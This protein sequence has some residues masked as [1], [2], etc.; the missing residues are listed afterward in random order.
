MDNHAYRLE[1]DIK[2]ARAYVNF[3]DEKTATA[4][5]TIFDRL[6]YPNGT[7]LINISA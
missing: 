6:L 5:A 1:T 7:K 4:L 2:K 3:A